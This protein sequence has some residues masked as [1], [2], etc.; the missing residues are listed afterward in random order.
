[1][2]QSDFDQYGSSHGACWQAPE[3]CIFKKKSDCV[4]SATMA[5]GRG[6]D[7]KMAGF[8]SVLLH[9]CMNG[10]WWLSD[11]GRLIF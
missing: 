4:F 7:A 5:A 10:A 2:T 6:A 3:D 11:E 9:A 1:L 8:G